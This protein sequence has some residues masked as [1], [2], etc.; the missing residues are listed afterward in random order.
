M[1]RE[2][3]FPERFPGATNSY[4]R[5]RRETRVARTYGVGVKV[6]KTGPRERFALHWKKDP[7]SDCWLWTAV[8]NRKGYGV[9]SRNFYGEALAHRFS[10]KTFRGPIPKGLFV[11]H[12]CDNPKCVNPS[13]LFLGTNLENMRDS[14]RKGRMKASSFLAKKLECKR[15]HPFSKENTRIKIDR[16]GVSRR[17]CRVCQR[18]RK[19]GEI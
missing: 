4:P 7:A 19:R 8:L 18:M 16:S 5:P 1:P 13:H 17:N 10:Y 9:M 6:V 3:T 2:R 12:H 15:G 14:A 11:C